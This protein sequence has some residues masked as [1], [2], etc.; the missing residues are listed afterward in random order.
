MI[1]EALSVDGCSGQQIESSN[2][3]P[4]SGTAL[5]HLQFPRSWVHLL[6]FLSY[7]YA[8]SC[9]GKT[10]VSPTERYAIVPDEPVSFVLIS[11]SIF[12]T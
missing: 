3:D 7:N 9:A 5:F 6:I 4:S 11:F 1:L 2:V 10:W 8:I 12:M